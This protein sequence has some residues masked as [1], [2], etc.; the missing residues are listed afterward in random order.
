LTGVAMAMAIGKLT[1]FWPI[2][3]WAVRRIFASDKIDP[4]E[5]TSEVAA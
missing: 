1:I 5:A 4:L 3:L 2:Q